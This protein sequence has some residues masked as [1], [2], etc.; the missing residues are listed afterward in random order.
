MEGEEK[1]KQPRRR[2]DGEDENV[3]IVVERGSGVMWKER[4]HMVGSRWILRRR[5]RDTICAHL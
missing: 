3:Y 4:R 2:E 1:K 5:G